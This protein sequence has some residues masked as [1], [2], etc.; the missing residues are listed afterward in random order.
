MNGPNLQQVFIC[1]ESMEVL[2]GRG[3][4][5]FFKVLHI[6]PLQYFNLA[7]LC[8]RDVRFFPTNFH[9]MTSIQA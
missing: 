7:N 6:T 5:E 3:Y 8:D 9:P 2:I 4:V 1:T